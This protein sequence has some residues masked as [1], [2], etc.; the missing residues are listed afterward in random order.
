MLTAGAG[1]HRVEFPGT[2]QSEMGLG[3]W[4]CTWHCVTQMFPGYDV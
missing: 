3:C 4:F 1:E 2:L